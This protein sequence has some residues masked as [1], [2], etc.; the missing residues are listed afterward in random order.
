MTSLSRTFSRA[1]ATALLLS[2]GALG[3]STVKGTV[4]LTDSRSG[5]VQ[6]KGD[7][8][9]VAVWLEPLNRTPTPHAVRKHAVMLQKDKRFTPHVLVVESGTNIDFP[10]ED[11]IFHNAFSNFDGQLFDIGLYPPGTSRTVKFDRPGVVRVF[12]VNRAT[13]P[14]N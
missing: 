8:S 7:Y 1:L 4:R 11:P 12:C 14:L 5:A 13:K 6:R 9:G 10:N 2:G 3:Q